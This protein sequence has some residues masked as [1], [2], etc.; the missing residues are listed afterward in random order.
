MCVECFYW[1]LESEWNTYAPPIYEKVS[2]K[3]SDRSD[4]KSVCAMLSEKRFSYGA[5][6]KAMVLFFNVQHE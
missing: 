6:V 5:N 3:F 1:I 4:F 2:V